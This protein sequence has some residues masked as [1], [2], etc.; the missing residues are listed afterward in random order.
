[1]NRD[2]RQDPE[3]AWLDA[4]LGPVPSS[5]DPLVRRTVARTVE[6]GRRRQR[7][8]RWWLTP[9]LAA[10]CAGGLMLLVGGERLPR[11]AVEL[12][13]V[14]T[15]PAA[16]LDEEGFLEDALDRPELLDTEL[17]LEDLSDEELQQMRVEL[18][19]LLES[20]P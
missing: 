4:Q 19:D 6:E 18:T 17:D 14:V 12:A 5:Q 20:E 1:M 8:G 3:T 16:E 15:E 2:D 13:P 9:A 7:T 10:V 11:R